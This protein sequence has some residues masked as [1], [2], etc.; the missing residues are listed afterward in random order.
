MLDILGVRAV[1]L[2]AMPVPSPAPPRPWRALRVGAAPIVALVALAGCGRPATEEECGRIVERI[3]KLE[4]AEAKI[5]DPK[6][7]AAQVQ[8]TKSALKATAKK[9][10]VGRRITAAALRC[11]DEA[12][13]ANHIIEVCF[14]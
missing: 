12:T 9:Q 10:C 2:S 11:V 8:R 3:T 7:I 1:K 13:S 4:L 5:G 6:N 14:D